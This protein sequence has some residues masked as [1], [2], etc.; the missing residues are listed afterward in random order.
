VQELRAVVAARRPAV[1][2]ELVVL[3]LL[4]GPRH[5][6]AAREQNVL[7]FDNTTPAY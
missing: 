5:T 7:Q 4:E 3:V 1:R 6:R 2:A